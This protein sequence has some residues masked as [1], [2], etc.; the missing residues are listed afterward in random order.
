MEFEIHPEALVNIDERGRALIQHVK[1]VSRQ[2]HG[3]KDF[4]T[5]RPTVT[6]KANDIS[7]EL[8]QWEKNIAPN[9]GG[10]L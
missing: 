9:H 3:A 2:R 4:P 6:I 5:E 1:E 7:G 10:L 8:L